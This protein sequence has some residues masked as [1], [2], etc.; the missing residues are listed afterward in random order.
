[1][2]IENSLWSGQVKETWPLDLCLP[3]VNRRR[4]TLSAQKDNSEVSGRPLGLDKRVSR[5]APFQEVQK[6]QQLLVLS[7]IPEKTHP[8]GCLLRLFA[9]LILRPDIQ[10]GSKQERICKT[11]QKRRIFLLI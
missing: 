5:S 9:S 11:F 7:S 1:M 10:N 4:Q 8:L 3:T 2:Q 6:F